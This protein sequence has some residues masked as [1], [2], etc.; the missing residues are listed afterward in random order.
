MLRS[1]DASYHVTVHKQEIKYFARDFRQSFRME[2]VLSKLFTRSSTQTHEKDKKDVG[3]PSRSHRSD[4]KVVRHARHR[5][6]R[7]STLHTEI[8]IKNVRTHA[9]NEAVLQNARYTKF[10]SDT[11]QL[12]NYYRAR[13]SAAPLTLS[14]R[15]SYIAQKYADYL[16]ATSKFEHSGNTFGNETLGENLYMQWISHGRVPVSAREAVKSWYD[17]I[18]LYNFKHPYYSEETGHFTQLIWKSTQKMGVGVALSADGREVYVVSNYYPTGN[19]INPGY[20][21]VNVLPGKS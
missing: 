5:Y 11:L 1:I 7:P 9:Q 3:S 14:Q 18:S 19:I 10:L 21:E 12:H 6:E 17:E 20:F 2:L 16:A 15:L 4:K 13:H 8:A